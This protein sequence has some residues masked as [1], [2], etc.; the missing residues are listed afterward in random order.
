MIASVWPPGI[1]KTCRTPS[2]RSVST[3]S[4]PPVTV[5]AARKPGADL[6]DR[7]E[8]CSALR[9]SYSCAPSD[10]AVG[11]EFGDL[12]VGHPEQLAVYVR[13][14]LAVARAHRG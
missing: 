1:P 4:S 8:S 11:C 7:C 5:A 3:T 10:H 12:A 2:A 14:V 9:L 6:V 13:V